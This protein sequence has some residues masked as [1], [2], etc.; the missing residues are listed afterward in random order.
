MNAFHPEV[1]DFV[2]ALLQEIVQNYEVDGVQGDDRLPACP[3]IAGYDPWTARLY[4]DQH[5]GRMPP[6]DHMEQGWIDWRADLLSKFMKRM[7]R[8][9]KSSSPQLI[10]SSAPSVYPWSKQEYLQDWPTWLENGWVDEVCPQI[11]RDDVKSYEAELKKIVVEQ[12][13]AKNLRFVYPGILVRTSD[14]IYKGPD[15]IRQ[16]V[17]V[18]RV[19]GFSGEVFFHDRA[20]REYEL[21]FKQL[22][23]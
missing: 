23:R 9:L 7:H 4:R 13:S 19:A 1:Q 2:L 6:A 8:Q 17:S 3:S 11:Y 12:V 15:I 14:Q 22:Y 18:N 21:L 16:M 5:E 20:V 10:V